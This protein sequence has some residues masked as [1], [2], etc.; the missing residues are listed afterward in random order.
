MRILRFSLWG[1]A[2]LATLTA[3]RVPA[4]NTLTWHNDNNRSGLNSAESVLTPANVNAKD[5]GKVGFITTDG[6]VTAQPL[7]V[8]GVKIAG[9]RNVLYVVTEHDSVYAKDAESGLWLWK[10]SL[11]KSGETPSDDQG[12][13]QI[14]PEIGITATPVIDLSKGPNGAIYVVAMTKDSAGK[15][16]QRISALDLVTGAQLFGGPTEITASYPGTGDNTQSGKVVFD[17]GQYAERAALLELNGSIYTTWTSHCDHRPYTGWILGYSASTLKQTAVFNMTP[18]GSE[19]AVWMSGAGP[20]AGLTKMYLLDANG[21]FDTSLDGTG[22]PVN[23][24]FGNAALALQPSGSSMYVSDYYSTDTTVQQSN[25][26]VDFGSGGLMM[27]PGAVTDNGGAQHLLIV[28]AGKDHNIYLI[29]RN[30]MGHYHPNG[31]WIYQVVSNALPNGE[32]GAPAYFNNKVYYGGVSD[33]LRAFSISNAKLVST[34][35][36]R[37]AETFVYPGTTP[38]ISSDGASN[39]IVWAVLH[40][41]TAAVLYAF[42][43]QDLSEELYAS[44]QSG[45]RDV[46][47]GVDHFMTQTVANGRVY[48]PTKTGI[49]IFGLLSN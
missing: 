21:S 36:S 31:G 25:A 26:D 11:L 45:S 13:T 30:N 16:H 18:N 47:G 22:M 33:T 42:N 27:I 46:F 40:S 29:D 44:N 41:G 24:D 10:T 49:A 43:A 8:A 48:V 20:A 28:A 17:P 3:P 7:Y 2:L 38:S 12:C 34:P 5:F 32:W 4:Q 37:S 6:V 1:A 19:G 35:S 14:S 39:G 9:T 23:H 15:Y